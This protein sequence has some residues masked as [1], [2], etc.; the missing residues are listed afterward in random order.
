MNHAQNLIRLLL[1]TF[2]LALSG[3]GYTVA[4][5]INNFAALGWPSLLMYGVLSLIVVYGG[6]FFTKAF[7]SVK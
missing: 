7:W 1:V 4:L 3:I 6:F 5:N 2:W